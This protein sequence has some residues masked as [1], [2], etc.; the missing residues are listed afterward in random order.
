[1]NVRITQIDGTL[2]NLSCRH[3]DG[4]G[5]FTTGRLAD[6]SSGGFTCDIM[7][8]EIVRCPARCEAGIRSVRELASILSPNIEARPTI[9]LGA[10][11]S[12]S[13]GVP[14]ERGVTG[15]RFVLRIEGFKH[16]NLQT[17]APNQREAPQP[18]AATH[19][20]RPVG[21]LWRRSETW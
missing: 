17:G 21:Q 10:G 9:L 14:L 8:L 5:W 1:V 15:G 11:A 3:C 13:S 6:T 19:A 12:F 18:A 4:N 16:S 7:M 2:P 20:R